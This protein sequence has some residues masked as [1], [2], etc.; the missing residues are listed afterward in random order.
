LTVSALTPILA[1]LLPAT[2]NRTGGVAPLRGNL[3]P[4][5]R[6]VSERPRRKRSAKADGSAKAGR[7]GAARPRR[8]NKSE[9]AAAGGRGDGEQQHEAAANAGNASRPATTRARAGKRARAGSAA[10]A[11]NNGRASVGKPA[12]D[13]AKQAPNA[14]AGTARRRAGTAP[15]SQAAAAPEDASGRR[16]RRLPKTHLSAKELREFQALLLQKRAEICGDVE[17][18]TDE[19][20]YRS[21]NGERDNAAMPIH[22]ADLGSDNWEQDFTLNLLANER[23]LVREI[24]EALARIHDKTYGI[25]LATHEPIGIPRLRA[26]PWAKYCIEYARAKEEGRVS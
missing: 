12:A 22:M 26:K 3:G 17:Q 13:S 7:A 8:P 15:A 14:G 5:E 24:D 6:P 11:Q 2:S 18:L 21:G 25:C 10:G 1:G 9:T 19:A 23:Q 16:P 4:T 20:L